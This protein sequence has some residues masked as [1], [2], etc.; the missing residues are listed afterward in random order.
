LAGLSDSSLYGERF[1]GLSLDDREPAKKS[2]PS[3]RWR[4]HSK[5]LLASIASV[6]TQSRP[7]GVFFGVSQ[8]RGTNDSTKYLPLK[9]RIGTRMNRPLFGTMSKKRPGIRSWRRCKRMEC[10][11]FF[12]CWM[13]R[14]L[15]HSESVVQR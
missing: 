10:L 9:L 6:G 4:L 5:R 2:C 1:L 15:R 7:S 3:Q 12:G 8:S 13:V 14:K 11:I